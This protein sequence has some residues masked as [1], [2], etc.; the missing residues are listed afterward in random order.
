MASGT[1]LLASLL[2]TAGQV[3]SD[4]DCLSQRSL[5]IPMGIDPSHRAEISHLVLYVSSDEGKNW[6]QEAVVPPEND[7]F[8]FFAPA[9]GMY[10]LRVAFV[11]KQGK[12]F[13]EDIT[14]GPPSRKL[15]ID[16]L[17]PMVRIASA[18]REG[19]E[20]TV[21]WEIQEEHPDPS[22]LKLEYRAVDAPPGQWLPVPASQKLIDQARLRPTSASPLL[23]RV[24]FKDLAGN[25][26]YDQKE[27]P[28]ANG[29]TAAS[30]KATTP[31]AATLSDPPPPA[32]ILDTLPTV[33]PAPPPEIK[34]VVA[35]G[36][37]DRIPGAS[38]ASQ[39]PGYS[40]P[41]VTV[42]APVQPAPEPEPKVVARSDA[43]RPPV[44]SPAAPAAS[45]GE[46]AH[47]ALPFPKLVN[48]PEV[49]LDYQLDKVGPSGIGSVELW[50]TPDDGQTWQRF[51]EDPDAK[52]LTSGSKYQRTVELPG[53]GI[54][55][56]RLVVKSKAGRGRPAPVSGNMPDLRVEVDT[57]PPEAVLLEP[58][59][60]PKR[61][62]AL[63]LQWKAKDRNLDD[64]PITLEY[65]DQLDGKWEKIA[66]DL[67]NMPEGYSWQVPPGKVSVYLRLR[68]RDRAGN[69]GIAVT[70]EPQLVDLSEPEGHLL[71]VSL[72]PRR[73]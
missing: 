27:V 6:H 52:A 60:D 30:F 72:S 54:Y 73:P 29:I 11:N 26:S 36:V 58:R 49:V 69:E 13:P 64:R 45:P 2:L 12:Q 41:P 59:P 61:R 47:S 42:P 35:P 24:Q 37:A 28:G 63:I 67:A 33:Q 34:S 4:V 8:L 21:A 70:S 48:N 62:D 23:V 3:P 68:V 39:P 14:K 16:T 15:L 32:P 5:R 18:R 43:P 19:D 50:L 56:F 40:P 53:E 55:G 46:P 25:L 31:D 1:L 71:D 7:A 57:T 51:A 44:A 66:T 22:S 65:A 17:K 38:G 20:V 9:D 10:W